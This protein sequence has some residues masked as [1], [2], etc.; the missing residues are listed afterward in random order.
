MYINMATISLYTYTYVYDVLYTCT[1]REYTAEGSPYGRGEGSSARLP[2]G[3]RTARTVR[4]W[5]GGPPADGAWREG[6]FK[7][8]GRIYIYTC[9]YIRTYVYVHIAFYIAS[10]VHL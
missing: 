8:E 7:W 6:A 3:A 2:G 4:A 9:I 5:G 1:Y 10:D